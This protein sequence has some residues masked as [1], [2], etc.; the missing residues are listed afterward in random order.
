MNH[1]RLAVFV[2]LALAAACRAQSVLNID[3]GSSVTTAKRGPAA[4][5]ADTNDVWNAYSHYAP[6]YAPGMPETADGRLEG[7]KFGD[8]SPSKVVVVVSNAPGVWQNKTGDPMFDSFIFATNSLPIT[9]TL[10]GLDPGRYEFALYGHADPDA[11]PGQNPGFALTP[12][13]GRTRIELAGGLAAGGWKAGDPWLEGR[14]YILFRDVTVRA[15]DPVVI[16]VL[17]GAGGV[18]VLNGLQILARGTS[19]P[20]LASAEVRPADGATNIV[21]REARY[22]AVLGEGEARFKVALDAEAPGTNEVSGAL[23]S[24]DVALVSPKLPD[25][26]RIT[27]QGGNITLWGRA[28]GLQHFEFEVVAKVNHADPWRTAGFTGPAAAVGSID[29]ASAVPDTEIQLD[30]GAAVETAAAT[31]DGPRTGPVRAALDSGGRVAL[32]WRNRAAET[33]RAA[34][35][36]AETD[37]S[38]TFSAAAARFSATVRLDVLQGRLTNLRF[39]VPAGQTVTRVEGDLV[40]GWRMTD[41]TLFLGKPVTGPP[42]GSVLNVELLRPLEGPASVT[43]ASEQPVGPLPAGVDASPVQSLDARREQGALR[44]IADDVLTA[45]GDTAGLRQINAGK[46]ETAA[47]RFIARP[48]SLHVLISRLAPRITTADRVYF[49]LEENRLRIRHALSLHVDRAGVY[50]IE[51]ALPPSLAVT[52]VVGE[53]IEDWKADAGKLVVRF[54]RRILGDAT[55]DIRVERAL[56]ENLEGLEIS[57]VRVAGAERATAWIGA[58]AAAGFDLKTASVTGAREVPAAILPQ[59]GDSLLA[60][61]A[62]GDDWRV[63]LSGERLS[64]R[65]VGQVFNL[66]AVG[67]GVVGGSA[68]LRYAIVNQGVRAFRVRLPEHWR[69]VEFTGANIRR[70]DHQGGLWTIVLQD[71]VWTAYTLV[72]TYDYPF[73]PAGTNL[74]ASGAHLVDVERETGAVAVTAAPG[75]EIKPLPVAAPLRVV[76]PTELDSADRGLISRPVL[77]AARYEGT[78]FSLTVAAARNQQISGINAVADHAQITSVL[79]DQGETL[80]EAS[81]MVKNN[82]LQFQRFRLPKGAVLWGVA[83]DGQPAKADR[84]GDWVLVPLPREGD[85]N[86]PF[87]VKLNYVQQAGDLRAGVLPKRVDLVAPSTD[88]PGA[89]AEWEVYAPTD[90]H[91]GAF[92]GSMQVQPGVVYSLHDAWGGFKDAYAAFFSEFGGA[93]IVFLV[94]VAC[95]SALW[96]LWSKRGSRGL[97]EAVALVAVLVIFA[98]MLLPALSKAKAKANRISSVNNLKNIGL[99]ARIYATD[100]DGRFP[101]NL[102]EMT[103]ITT[104]RILVHPVTGE[105]YTWIGAG[106]TEEDPQIIVGYGPIVDGGVDV[107]FADGSVQQMTAAKFGA[108]FQEQLTRARSKTAFAANGVAAAKPARAATGGFGGMAGREAVQALN[109]SAAPPPPASVPAAGEPQPPSVDAPAPVAAGLKSLNI[110]LPRTGR[111]FKFTR[112]L[113]LSGEPP[114]VSFSV[115]SRREF[116]LVRT[117]AQSLSFLIGLAVAAFQWSR[118]R[119]SSFW[120]AAGVASAA[121]A[122]GHLFLS[123]GALHVVF[124]V[125]PPAVLFLFVLLGLNAFI[126]ASTRRRAARAAAP[127][128]VGAALVA[129]AFVLIPDPRAE[130]ADGLATNAATVLALD[131]TGE[132]GDHAARLEGLA[133]FSAS[134]SNQTAVLFGPEAAVEEFTPVAGAPRPWRSGPRMGVSLSVPGP[135]SARIKAVF[136]ITGDA[137]HRTLDLGMPTA[138]G[139][140]VTLFVNDPDAVVDS[141]AALSLAHTN[142][143]GR[144]RIDAV[145]GVGDRMTLSWS[146]R[147]GVPGAGAAVF[148]HQATL[149]TAGSGAVA[150]RSRIRFEAAQGEVGAVRIA[151][152]AGHRLMRVSGDRLSAWNTSAD[153]G[154]ELTAEFAKPMAAA[155]LVVDTETPLDP[156]PASFNAAVPT[157]LDVRGADGFVAIRPADETALTVETTADL[158]RVDA[159]DFTKAFGE[160]TPDLAGAWRF[161]RPAFSLQVRAGTLTPV[162]EALVVNHFS[163]AQESVT[164]RAATRF[165]VTRSGAF[166]VR[167]ALPGDAR[168]DLVECPAMARWEEHTAD[169]LRTLEI[170]LNQKTLGAFDVTV[171]LVRPLKE[172]TPLLDLAGVHPVDASK[173]SG[174]VGVAAEAGV[175]LKTGAL[176]G[177][178]EIPANEF[179]PPPGAPAATLAFKYL[180]FSAGSD[181]H[182]KLQIAAEALDSWVRAEIVHQLTVGEAVVAGRAVVRYDIQNAPSKDFRLAVP[183]AWRNVE[184]EGA[185]IRRRELFTNGALV[186]YRVELQSKVRGALS[187]NLTWEQ[188]AGTNIALAGV[189]ALGAERETGWLALSTKGRIQLT[190]R[191]DADALR[192]ADASELPDWARPGDG[193]ARPALVYRYLRPGWGASVAADRFSDAAVLQALADSVELLT[194]VSDDGQTISRLTLRIRNN[195]RQNLSAGTIQLGCRYLVGFL[196]FKR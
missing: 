91:V 77:F 82:E 159:A 122:A 66:V 163:V 62:E 143:N 31:V 114:S 68:T 64:A 98:G 45:I 121:L 57:P 85:R 136:K 125:I 39:A 109:D 166:H 135:A 30:A 89:Y 36:A 100:H 176:S 79:N 139:A 196:G 53:A 129:A 38:V 76:D 195:G 187:L 23:F 9:V 192:R 65:L 61:R 194:V 118:R 168:V 54:S 71:K 179:T 52:E 186:E 128:P 92:G 51:A 72:V 119:P 80:T 184:I 103:E 35:V 59:P 88:V 15:G 11:G 58:S 161:V 63:A 81:F 42:A 60:Y 178:M 191:V 151:L 154:G 6:R 18:A 25:G 87:A 56:P 123:W 112:T 2:A 171:A 49:Q 156:P 160:N 144:T 152:P 158:D 193:A 46:G 132:A 32:R 104:P 4:F 86:R 17:P 146:P 78:N 101:K 165:T 141:P 16:E 181:P 90:R 74:D 14:Q 1:L 70:T 173:V 69:N 97:L 142:V 162:I 188:P 111:Y 102:E 175:G 10:A 138:L 189:Q 44:V 115:M 157:P 24:G 190:L 41:S 94:V 8:G 124:I 75:V 134:S 172:L 153:L 164:I 108:V 7:L 12:G 137:V 169:G 110:E 140:K 13:P 21:F 105:R 180:L 177:L 131:W 73:N 183:A 33:A 34:V 19:P 174:F 50:G 116:I 155:T 130:A 117:A 113:N 107:L 55:L 29:A 127:S 3:F 145:F 5:G 149:V 40:R 95:G 185:A 28:S 133:A 126:R 106:V 37:A 147:R 22:T 26:W 167:L 99:A 150:F 48:A 96:L 93:L 47:F 43:I 67:D 120:L 170:D 83:V 84:D 20:R 27:V 148:A 182:W